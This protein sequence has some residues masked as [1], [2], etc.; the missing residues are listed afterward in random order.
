MADTVA[1]EA[2]GTALNGMLDDYFSGVVASVSAAGERAISKMTQLT[3]ASAP[4]SSARHRK[5]RSHFKASIDWRR[6]Q[7]TAVGESVFTWYVKKPNYRLTHLLENPHATRSGG[8]VAGRRFVRNAYQTV[9]ADYEA[10]IKEA[11]KG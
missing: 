8:V 11:V 5:G 7:G 9:I 6:E 2:F 4:Y 1:P 10:E 3:Q